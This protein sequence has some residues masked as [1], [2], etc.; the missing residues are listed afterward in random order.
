M[1]RPRDWGGRGQQQGVRLPLP[2]DTI[3]IVRIAGSR[4]E[5]ISLWLDKYLTVNERWELTQDIK[6]LKQFLESV[7][8]LKDFVDALR[9]RYDALLQ[10]YERRGYGV[11]KFEA[12]P[13]WR[14]VVGLGM[15]HVLETSIVLHRIFDLPIIPASGL[16]GVVRM[17]ALRNL[18][19]E[20]GVPVFSPEMVIDL[21]YQNMETLFQ[22]LERLV[23]NSQRR[24]EVLNELLRDRYLPPNA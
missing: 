2:S 3:R 6:Q 17:Y 14:F 8:R 24:W 23:I 13:V 22:R 18:V 4:C 10:W 7:G 21:K 16:K 9:R 19:V 20:L 1:E 11:R 5:N 12:R 15:V